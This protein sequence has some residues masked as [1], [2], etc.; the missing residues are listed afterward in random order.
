MDRDKVLEEL[1]LEKYAANTVGVAMKH[2]VG[3]VPLHLFSYG[4][5]I[6]RKT[7]ALKKM[8]R[9][10]SDAVTDNAENLINPKNYN[11]RKINSK[12]VSDSETINPY[13]YVGK[14][15]SLLDALKRGL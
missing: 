12:G 2:A 3:Q 7:P 14:K 13:V 1:L 4:N 5:K 10:I 15:T 9:S 11:V 8:E 6:G